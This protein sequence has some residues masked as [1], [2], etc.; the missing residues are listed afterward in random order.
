MYKSWQK[1]GVSSLDAV[2]NV[3]DE[4]KPAPWLCKS[5]EGAC[6]MVD[7]VNHFASRPYDNSAAK[8]EEEGL[9]IA[10]NAYMQKNYRL[11]SI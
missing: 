1:L 8:S 11:S 2:A 7:F 3:L 6:V 5:C 4:T 10:L 9:G